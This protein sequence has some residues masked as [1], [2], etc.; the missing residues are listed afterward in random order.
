MNISVL[1]ENELMENSIGL[2]A[3]HGLSLLIE[4]NGKKILFDAGSSDTFIENAKKMGVKLEDIDIAVLSHAHADHSGGMIKFLELNSQANVYMSKNATQQCYFKMGFLKKNISVS[5]ALFS[6]HAQRISYI[7]EMTEITEGVYLIPNISQHLYS[8]GEAQKKLLV[9]KDGQYYVDPFEHEIMMLIKQPDKM[10]VVTGCSHN[11]VTNMVEAAI[12][13]FPGTP[14]Q[15]LVGG[16]HLMGLPFKKTLGENK[17]FI[18][19]LAATMQR[20]NIQNIYTCHCTGLKAYEILKQTMQGKLQY[21][22]TGQQ[23]SLEE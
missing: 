6:E 13:R 15:A 3:E 16:F 21:I 10:V 17:P 23:I 5:P 2:Q 4:A 11:G 8:R 7:D 1:I 9:K 18:L 19:D 12:T 22:K 14:I 20:F